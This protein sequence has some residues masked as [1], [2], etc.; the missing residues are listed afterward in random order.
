MIYYSRPYWLLSETGACI[1]T[2]VF[3]RYMIMMI[4]TKFLQNVLHGDFASVHK[5]SSLHTI[6]N[7]GKFSDELNLVI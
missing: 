6:L 2:R 4:Y 1:C 3:H 7:I 5:L